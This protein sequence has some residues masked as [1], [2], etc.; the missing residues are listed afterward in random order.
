[1]DARN[2]IGAPIVRRDAA[3]KARGTASYAAD[4]AHE[5]VAYAALTLSSVAKGRITAIDT[6]AA[7]AVAGVRAVLTHRSFNQ[8]LSGETFIMK[9]GHMQSS[10]MPLQSDEVHYEGQIVG[11]VIA[12]TAEAAEEAARK[13]KV[14]Y[15]ARHASASMD[16]PDRT[17][18]TDD[19]AGVT[20]GDADA[21]FAA[22]P[23]RIDSTYVTPVQHHNPIE[24]YATTAAWTG[25]KLV[26][27]MP[28]QWVMGT[29][30]GPRQ[31]LRHPDGGH[32]HREPLR[33]RRLRL[34]GEPSY[35]PPCWWPPPPS[36]WAGRSSW[37][38]R[39]RR[40]GRWARSARR[41]APA[42]R[43]G[44]GARDGT[45]KSII[46][47]EAAQSAE[48]DHVAFPRHIGGHPHVRQ[49]DAA[50]EAVD[51]RHRRQHAGLRARAGGSLLVLRLR[52]RHGRTRRG[53]RTWTRSRFA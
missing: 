16:D 30:A 17:S 36:G 8:G 26:V 14:T 7:D 41:P 49:P 52:E 25:D 53:A 33:R 22:A 47:E 1:M 34:Q 18:E 9:G 27:H 5:N 19:D 24:L 39:A 28:S 3:A 13:L 2:G 51:G 20:K 50:H 43:I 38:C 45:L 11:L 21:A 42:S 6:G 37:W 46:F 12:D 29:Q 15:A 40:C 32:T 35:P 4:V 44:A 10:L 31:D 23:V 48:I